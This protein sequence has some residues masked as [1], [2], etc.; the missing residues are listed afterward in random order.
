MEPLQAAARLEHGAAVLPERARA[1]RA[2]LDLAQRQLH[3]TEGFGH[4][5]NLTGR[6]CGAIGACA[7]PLYV[8]FRSRQTA[9][10]AAS[11]MTTSLATHHWHTA[12]ISASCA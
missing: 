2:R 8:L 3:A 1:L 9:A 6:R 10:I 7:E 4:A 11:A 12:S 5:R